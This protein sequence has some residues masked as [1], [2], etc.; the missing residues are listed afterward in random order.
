M[1]ARSR[2]PSANPYKVGD[3]VTFRLGISDLQ[4]VIVEDRGAIGVGGRR[5]YRIRFTFDSEEE[6][7][8][9]LA[10]QDFRVNR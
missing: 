7:F 1:K 9:E 3:K 5:L 10:A 4:G 6:R 2:T 8:I